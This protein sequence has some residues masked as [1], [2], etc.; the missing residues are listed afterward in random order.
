MCVSVLSFHFTVST[1]LVR[2]SSGALPEECQD[3]WLLEGLVMSALGHVTLTTPDPPPF[4]LVPLPLHFPA[5]FCKIREN[6]IK[7]FGG[8][9]L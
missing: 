5:P 1:L 3:L 8:S 6:A 7:C 4:W 2:N 9:H